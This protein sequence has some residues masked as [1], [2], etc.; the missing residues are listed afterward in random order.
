MFLMGFLPQVLAAQPAQHRDFV[1]CWH[2]GI[3]SWM[4]T[5][6]FQRLKAAGVTRRCTHLYGT[7]TPCT[8]PIPLSH[9]P[10]SSP[11][12]D[13]QRNIRG[14]P[15][16]PTAPAALQLLLP[17]PVPPQDCGHRGRS[18][19]PAMQ[20]PRHI[21]SPLGQGSST[22]KPGGILPTS[23]TLMRRD[24]ETLPLCPAKCP[25]LGVISGLCQSQGLV[26]LQ[27]NA[28][29]S[30]ETSVQAPTCSQRLIPE[31]QGF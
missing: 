20:E 27:R 6:P 3:E 18:P 4:F 2:R 11:W 16:K 1:L 26:S 7:Y 17:C 23:P 19:A 28:A 31:G 13:R 8:A 25:G 10:S 9:P 21:A 12:K 15:R 22:S 30:S 29:P 24:G 5:N 14:L